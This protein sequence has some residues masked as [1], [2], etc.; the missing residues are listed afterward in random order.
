[1]KSPLVSSVRG[2]AFKWLL[3]VFSRKIL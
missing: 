3:K 2:E 1:M